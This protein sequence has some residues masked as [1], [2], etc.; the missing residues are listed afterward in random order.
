MRTL[1]SA[2]IT[3]YC[4]LALSCSD[5]SRT[6]SL[7]SDEVRSHSEL[8]V[9]LEQK[10][11]AVEALPSLALVREGEPQHIQYEFRVPDGRVVSVD[12]IITE[13]GGVI[14]APDFDLNDLPD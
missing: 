1:K 6:T 7:E 5:G 4:I 3:F 2:A 11:G 14:V 13:S 8:L 9:Y 12:D 10:Y